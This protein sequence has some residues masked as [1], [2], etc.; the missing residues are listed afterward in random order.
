MVGP[1]G[2]D[3]N[4]YRTTRQGSGRLN[5]ESGGLEKV[6]RTLSGCDTATQTGGVA[7]VPFAAVSQ[8]RELQLRSSMGRL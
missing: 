1:D 8:P 2:H 5:P 7:T 6:A 3:G 4:G